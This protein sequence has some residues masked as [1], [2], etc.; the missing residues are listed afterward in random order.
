LPD[1]E[2]KL[3]EHRFHVV[4]IDMK[5]PTGSGQDLLRTLRNVDPEARAVLITGY[6]GEMEAKVQNA[7]EAGANAVCYKPFDVEKLLSTVEAL[8]HRGSPTS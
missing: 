4:L 7:L 1:A 2:K 5:L 3:A 8:S 6:R